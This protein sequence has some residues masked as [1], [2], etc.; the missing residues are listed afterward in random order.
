MIQP[1]IDWTLQLL[2]KLRQ[3]DKGS[4]E[5]WLGV[6]T[7]TEVSN[8]LDKNS[9]LTPNN[10][11]LKRIILNYEDGKL[12]RIALEGDT[13]ALPFSFLLSLTEEYKRTFNTYDPIDD[14]Q[15]I[16]YPGKTDIS[17]VAIESWIPLEKQTDNHISIQFN[18]IYF[19]LN[20]N[21][22]PY[23]FRDGW[24]LIVPPK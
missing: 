2:D 1:D 16:F 9:F 14:E 7:E 4:L 13:F 20:V 12:D 23:H 24:H 11:R 5:S 19:H 15:F 22:V 10:S 18:D 8:E 3:G 6:T 21:K 17:I